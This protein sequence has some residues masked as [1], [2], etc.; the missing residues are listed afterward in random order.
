MVRLWGAEL[1][2]PQTGRSE[3]KAGPLVTI[4]L[5]INNIDELFGS[6]WIRPWLMGDSSIRSEA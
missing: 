4:R 1:N 5:Y 6:D 2:R 3:N